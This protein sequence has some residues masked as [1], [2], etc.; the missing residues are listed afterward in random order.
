MNACKKVKVCPS[1]SGVNAELKSKTLVERYFTC[2]KMVVVFYTYIFF[3]M[4]I[5]PKKKYTFVRLC[6]FKQEVK[7]LRKE[8]ENEQKSLYL[9]DVI[10]YALNIT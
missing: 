7:R 1:F 4:F 8:K 9:Y 6:N 2:Q 3:I 10:F 5:K